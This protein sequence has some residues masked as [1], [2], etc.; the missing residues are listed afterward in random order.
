ML[1]R[2]TTVLFIECVR[3]L[4]IFNSSLNIL[5]RKT[6]RS[7]LERRLPFVIKDGDIF[8]LAQLA[9][10]LMNETI[11][12]GHYT[13]RTFSDFQNT[14]HVPAKEKDFFFY[15][16]T[17]LTFSFFSQPRNILLS[18]FSLRPSIASLEVSLTV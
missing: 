12:V 16:S 4:Y 5:E 10:G 1:Q 6:E 13:A 11:R 2:H 7:Y 15:T 14:H 8:S 17:F 18:C 9:R 3:L